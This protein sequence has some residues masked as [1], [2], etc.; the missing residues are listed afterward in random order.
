MEN[1]VRQFIEAHESDSSG[2]NKT[3]CV[4]SRELKQQLIDDS[5]EMANMPGNTHSVMGPVF[6]NGVQI[7]TPD[8]QLHFNPK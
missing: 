4:V 6:C 2:K 1:L 5:N 3:F 8:E 7:Y